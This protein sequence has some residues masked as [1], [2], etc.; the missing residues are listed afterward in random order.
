MVGVE[1][2]QL[3]SEIDGVDVAGR[4]GRNFDAFAQGV[5]AGEIDAQVIAQNESDIRRDERFTG[6]NADANTQ[7]RVRLEQLHRAAP[8][9]DNG[10]AQDFGAAVAVT[11]IDI[12]DSFDNFRGDRGG[13]IFPPR[14]SQADAA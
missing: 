10:D 12:G 7:R 9:I 13:L 2:G 3:E 1:F 6:E 4:H 11:K 5:D 8:I 14:H